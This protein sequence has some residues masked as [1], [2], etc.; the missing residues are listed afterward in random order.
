MSVVKMLR[1][2]ACPFVLSIL[3]L[4]ATSAQV[5]AATQY[6]DTNGTTAGS[7]VTAAGTYSWEDPNWNTA[8]A[9][10]ANAANGIIA[11]G[12][13][14]EGNF[15]RFAAGADAATFTY[16]VTANSSHS[17]AGMQ[18]LIGAAFTGGPTV[19]GGATVNV[20]TSGAALLQIA[21]GA[22]SSGCA[23]RRRTSL[24]SRRCC[25]RRPSSCPVRAA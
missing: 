9:N 2:F 6:F 3:S 8:G 10:D 21:P 11:T 15:P 25:F 5:Q 4:G 18:V 22:P 16:T 14:T 23:P 20:N 12:N 19:N 13:W 24:L 17:I 1:R 7:G